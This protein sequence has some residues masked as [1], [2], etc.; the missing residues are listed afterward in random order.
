MKTD[1]VQLEFLTGMT[2]FAG[3]ADEFVQAIHSRFFRR[4]FSQG[5][6]IHQQWSECT[7]L[8]VVEHGFVQIFRTGVDGREHTL[9]YLSDNDIINIVPL[10][11]ETEPLH[12]ANAKALTDTQMLIMHKTDLQQCMQTYP[13]FSINLMR[14]L[15]QRMKAVSNLTSDLALKDVRSRLAGFLVDQA[16]ARNS[17]PQLTQDEIGA[18]VGSVRDVVGRLLRDFESQGLIS[19]V[20]HQLILLDRPGLENIAEGH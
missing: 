18:M 5:E 9:A 15:A 12:A 2:L 10:L 4:E 17:S 16:D 1:A 19:R 13:Q 3:L 6:M 20:R 7:S 14:N 8:Y 11:T